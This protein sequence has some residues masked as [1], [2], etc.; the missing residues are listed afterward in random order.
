MSLFCLEGRT[1][2]VTGSSRGI[3]HALAIAMGNAGARIILNGRNEETL[4]EAAANLAEQGIEVATAVFDVTDPDSVN[5]AI[6]G[7]ESEISQIDILVNNAG[8]QRRASLEDFDDDDWR[9]LLA[10]NLDSV[11]YVSKAVARHMIPRGAGKIINIGSVMCELARPTIAPYTASKGGVRN[12]TRGMC[13]DWARH[14]LQINA[15]GPGYFATPLNKALVEDPE[16]DAWLKQRT[17]AGRWGDLE[18]LHG[19]VVFL[20]SNASNF[21]NGHT[22]YVDGGMTTVV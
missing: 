19:A 10:T 14:G 17:P 4:R 13:A 7:I 15:I 5:S 3:G 20:A 8:I 12:L 22:L 2:L 9:D 6:D 18:D 1:A 11:Y 21:V 16:F